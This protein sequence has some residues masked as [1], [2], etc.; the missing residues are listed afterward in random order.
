MDSVIS[1]EG[2]KTPLKRS[3]DGNGLGPINDG[4]TACACTAVTVRHCTYPGLGYRGTRC[5]VWYMAIVIWDRARMYILNALIRHHQVHS[6]ANLCTERTRDASPSITFDFN[7][8]I[9]VRSRRCLSRFPSLYLWWT[10]H[11]SNTN[12][13]PYPIGAMANPEKKHGGRNRTRYVAGIHGRPRVGQYLLWPIQLL[14]R[15]SFLTRFYWL[16]NV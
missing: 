4:P 14:N 10:W 7:L 2:I 12:S 3:A 9:R 13:G 6:R 1:V 5:H 15:I 8:T 11:P 16:V